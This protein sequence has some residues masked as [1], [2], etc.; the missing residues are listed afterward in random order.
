[1]AVD[2]VRIVTGGSFDPPPEGFEF[3][4]E[5]WIFDPPV[6]PGAPHWHILANPHTLSVHP[7]IN[8]TLVTLPDSGALPAAFEG[9]NIAWFGD[10]ATGTYCGPDYGNLLVT[11]VVPPETAITGGPSGST[12]STDALFS[13]ESSVTGSSFECS[14]DTGG[15]EPCSSPQSYSRLSLGEH[16]FQVRATDPAGNVDPTPAARTWTVVEGPPVTLEDLPNPQLAVAVNVQ[17]VAGE[18]LVGIPA[19]AARATARASQRGVQFVPL[20]EARQVP[21]GS[22]LDTKNGT[23][24]LQSA[25]DRQG[26]RQNGDFSRGLFQVRQSRKRSARGLTELRLKGGSFS[27]CRS[28]R[29]RRA[30][31]AARSRAVRRLRGNARGRFRTRGRGSAGTIRGTVWDTIDRC[32]GTLTKVKKGRVLVRDFGRRRNILVRAGKRYLA[33]VRTGR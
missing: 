11:Q 23:V 28:A 20:S 13:F 3:G 16:S 15:F 27:G 5:G 26:T 7:Q 1:V 31:R 17:A 14:L 33:R 10:D 32:D 22:F 29:S 21:V 25:R 4:A 30:A 8:P 2:D 19:G 6:P 24:R 9:T 18:V 12:S